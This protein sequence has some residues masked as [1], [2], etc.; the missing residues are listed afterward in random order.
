MKKYLF[1]LLSALCLLSSCHEDPIESPLPDRNAAKTVF[2]YMPWTGNSRNLY[3]FFQQNILDIKTA[4]KNQNGLGDKNLMIF[5]SESS[6]SGVLIKV[7][8]EEGK[9]VDDTLRRYQNTAANKLALNS[10]HWIT[11]ILNQVKSYA[12]ADTYAMIIG[13]HGYGWLEAKDF[14]AASRNIHLNA[15]ISEY[16][17]PITRSTRWFGGSEAKTDISALVSGISASGIKKLQYLMFDDCNMSN[18]ETAYQLKEVTGYLIGCPTEIMAFGMPYAKI[19]KHLANII[20]DYQA[21]CDEFYNFYNNY[22]IG[23]T[24][25][26]CG[27]IGIT[28]CSQVDSIAKIMKE[29]NKQYTFNTSLINSIQDLDGYAPPIFYDFG[30]YVRNLCTDETLRNKFQAQLSRTVPYKSN[31]EY[32]YSSLYRPGKHKINTYSGITISDLST[33]SLAATGMKKTA[34]WKATHK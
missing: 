16:D 10:S 2:V 6:T 21:I 18:I 12:P 7:R 20:P 29:I 19:W 34:W 5:I 1:I 11:Y 31:T 28:D 8:Y 14:T 17:G 25:Y 32:Y 15:K 13:S 4:I 23:G 26:H 3:D 33:N 30:D 24:A 9:C 22:E 27:T